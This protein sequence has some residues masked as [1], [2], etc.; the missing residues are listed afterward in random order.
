MAT[1]DAKNRTTPGVTLLLGLLLLI[2]AGRFVYALSASSQGW[3]AVTYMERVYD[4]QD[5]QA[6]QPSDRERAERRW[7]PLFLLIMRGAHGLDLS[8][9]ALRLAIRV[10][11]TAI[12]VLTVYLLST[13]FSEPDVCSDR[14]ET[15]VRRAIVVFL[16][17]QSTAAIY[18]IANGM[19]EVLTAFCVIGHL[20][21]FRRKQ[22]PPAA[23]LLCFGVYFK[24]YPIVFLF[25]YVMFSL[26]SRDH[27]PYSGYVLLSA[28]VLAS[29]SIP[30]SGWRY[31]FFYPYAMVRDVTTDTGVIPIRSK[32]VFGLL[33][34]V[35]RVMSSFSVRAAYPDAV[36]HT[37]I[38]T[39]I[40]AALLIASTAASAIVLARYEKTWNRDAGKRRIALLVFQSVIGFLIASFSLDMSITLVLPIMVSVYAPLWLFA[41]PVFTTGKTSAF[42]FVTFA[43]FGLGLV[44]VGNLIP[45]SMVL[46]GLPLAGLD[47]LAGNA[48]TDLIPLEKFIWYQV[49]LLGVSCI[50]LSAGCSL[51][52]LRS[53]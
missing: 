12:Y 34:L 15:I 25:P 9:F 26:L 24:L 17:F 5:R 27:R 21:Y 30:V 3:S 16:C 29:V 7:G 43:L 13:L 40:F 32:E 50:G 18:A 8:P 14:R 33:F 38:L 2:G 48:P 52:T 35:N 23:L 6:A 31:G 46:K 47:Y 28:L 45:L 1:R 19:G 36:A 51:T 11:L 49:P 41:D 44:L 4:G 20:Y 53:A 22:Y 42:A 37:K 10:F 39:S